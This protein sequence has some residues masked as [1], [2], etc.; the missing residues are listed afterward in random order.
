MSGTGPGCQG[1]ERQRAGVAQRRQRKRVG[2]RSRQ[3]SYGASS[4][5]D[6]GASVC[7]ARETAAT[8][9]VRPRT[10]TRQLV[11]PGTSRYPP[12]LGGSRELGRYNNHLS[13]RL[14]ASTPYDEIDRNCSEL[15]G[16]RLQNNQA[17]A[18]LQ[19]S[20]PTTFE[21]LTLLDTLQGT[22]SGAAGRDADESPQIQETVR[23]RAPPAKKRCEGP[24]HP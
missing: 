12:G 6:P 3:A 8:T 18:H 21:W 17:E 11:V 10:Y 5:D 9:G 24:R 13:C 15:F 22:T 16:L 4:G 19:C 1:L 20:L 2:A 7:T 14:R 23:P